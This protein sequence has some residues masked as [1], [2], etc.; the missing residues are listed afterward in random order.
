AWI[1]SSSTGETKQEITRTV[2]DEPWPPFCNDPA[3]SILCQKNL[4]NRVS[5][6]YVKNTESSDPDYTWDAATFYTYDIHG[7]VDTLLQDYYTGMGAIECTE[8][9]MRGNR[10]KKMVYSYDLISGKV[11]DVAYQ[12]NRTDQFYH[13]YDYDAENKLT[14]VKTS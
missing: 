7:N 6:T 4:R 2:Y 10:F 9:T 12:P 1:N 5:Y 14:I 13:H 11:N 3:T 8:D